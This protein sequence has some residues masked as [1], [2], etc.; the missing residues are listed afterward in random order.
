MTAAVDL[1]QIAAWSALRFPYVLVR[2][3]LETPA[4]LWPAVAG[5]LALTWA[6]TRGR[7]NAAQHGWP[8]QVAALLL[9]ALTVGWFLRWGAVDWAQ[10]TDW[11][12]EW[13]YFSALQQA[14]VNNTMPYLMPSSFQGTERYLANL[15]TVVAPHALLFKV[16]SIPQFFLVHALLAFAVGFAG[17]A[18]L[19]REL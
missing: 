15:E 3:L 1:L 13:A 19:R 11:Q 8:V 6:W 14:V 18:A 4:A 9:G 10:T 5:L 2:L 12:K 7:D 17:L 16:I